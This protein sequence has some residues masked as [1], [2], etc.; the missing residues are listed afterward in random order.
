MGRNI[1][2]QMILA[3][4]VMVVA[5]VVVVI[6]V[7]VVVEVAVMEVVSRMGVLSGLVGE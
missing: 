1:D 6:M 5:E 3:E 4:V 2:R 7:V